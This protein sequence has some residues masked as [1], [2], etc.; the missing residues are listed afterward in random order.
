MKVDMYSVLP[1][2]GI[3]KYQE[4]IGEMTRTARSSRLDLRIAPEEKE[5]IERAA[6]LTGNNTTDFVRSTTLTAA[7]EAIRTHE[8]IKLTVEGS[9]VFVEALINPPEP[10]EN[11]RRLAEEF[12]ASVGH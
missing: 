10:N 5:L 11:L 6:A 7:R 8:V 4:L 3:R 9:R 12:G 1:Y 2:N